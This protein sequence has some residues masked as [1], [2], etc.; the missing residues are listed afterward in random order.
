M[1]KSYKLKI[2][3]TQYDRLG[4]AFELDN[5]YFEK[6]IAASDEI[7]FNVSEDQRKSFAKHAK[8][9]TS[10]LYWITQMF[11]PKNIKQFEVIE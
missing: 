1:S 8:S 5:T 7:I 10:H 9:N 6:F 2:P 11:L 4:S 3:R